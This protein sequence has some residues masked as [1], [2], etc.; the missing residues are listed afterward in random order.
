MKLA[1]VAL[2]GL[3]VMSLASA[4]DMSGPVTYQPASGN[5]FAPPQN[6]INGVTALITPYGG[7][8]AVTGGSLLT[9]DAGDLLTTDS[10]VLL[11]N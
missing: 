6:T 1:L 9:D 10:G 5:N 8:G 7:N 2:A 3:T 4:G 11:T